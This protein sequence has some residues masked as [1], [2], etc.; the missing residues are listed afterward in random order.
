MKSG[1]MPIAVKTSVSPICTAVIPIK[2]CIMWFKI[3][4]SPFV[5]MSTKSNS[6]GIK[7]LWH[8]RKIGFF[9]R[10]LQ[11]IYIADIFFLCQYVPEKSHLYS[12]ASI[13]FKY[14]S[15]RDNLNNII[16][17]RV[18]AIFMSRRYRLALSGWV[19]SFLYKN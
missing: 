3:S 17:I 16:M 6:F 4:L 1:F 18:I 10:F 8:L 13:L 12:R 19:I 7:T 11:S 9:I 14:H 15:D 2:L 5:I